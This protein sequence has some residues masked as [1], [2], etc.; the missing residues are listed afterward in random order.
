MERKP[1]G[2]LLSDYDGTLC[3]TTSVRGDSSNSSGM[4]PNELEQ[5]LVQLSER[6]PLCII[7]SKDFAFLH[8]RVRFA[9][10]LSCALGIETIITMIKKLSTL[11]V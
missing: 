11:I 4:I 3:P 1:I 2:I 6:I 8:E 10:I 9:N 7:S 5:A